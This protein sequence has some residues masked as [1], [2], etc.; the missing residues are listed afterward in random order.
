MLGY[1]NHLLTSQKCIFRLGFSL[2]E[3]LKEECDRNSF[4]GLLAN[5]RSDES[6][7]TG[8]GEARV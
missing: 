4:S 3:R 6:S 1:V 2:V 5:N 8:K 7:L